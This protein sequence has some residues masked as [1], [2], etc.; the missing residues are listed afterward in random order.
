MTI[1]PYQLRIVINQ[2]TLVYGQINT[3]HNEHIQHQTVNCSTPL[4][5]IPQRNI[6]SQRQLLAC[7]SND[8]KYPKLPLALTLAFSMSETI[9]SALAVFNPTV[10]MLIR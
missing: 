2:Q 7:C 6:S 1:S 9:Q 5:R 10:H 3:E 4:Q 8:R